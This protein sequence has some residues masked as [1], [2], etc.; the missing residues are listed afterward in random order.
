MRATLLLF[1][2]LL[3]LCL[4]SRVEAECV[5]DGEKLPV[6]E[7]IRKC[8]KYT[9]HESGSLSALGCPA[10]LCKEQIGYR[11]EDLSKPYPEC[12]EGPICKP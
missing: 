2:I 8:R 6:G 5:V 1:G 7:H 10:Y 9:C 3:A 12:C 4:F 11:K